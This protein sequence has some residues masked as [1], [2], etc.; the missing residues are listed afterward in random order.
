MG[1]NSGFK[2]LNNII[3]IVFTYSNIQGGGTHIT[4]RRTGLLERKPRYMVITN[5]RYGFKVAWCLYEYISIF[6]FPVY[7]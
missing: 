6:F 4:R 1:F 7:E 2:G 3:L 5:T